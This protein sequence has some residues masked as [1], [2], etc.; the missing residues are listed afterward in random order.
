MVASA[1]ASIPGLD[2]PKLL[3]DRNSS[4]VGKLASNFDAQ[5]VTDKVSSTP[6]LLVGRTGQKP[7]PVALKSSTD[8]A[9]LVAAL[10]TALAG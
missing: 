1:A 9:S 5:A 3:A 8:E 6:T 4:A 10:D 7:K 2:V